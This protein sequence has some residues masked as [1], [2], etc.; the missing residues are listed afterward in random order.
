MGECEYINDCPFFNDKLTD[1]EV[2]AD[3][4]KEDYCRINNLHCARY[5]VAL[6]LGADA[7]PSGLYPHEKEIAFSLI[8]ESV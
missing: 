6:A 5:M 3:K 2:E 7:V 8:A 4:L 1:K